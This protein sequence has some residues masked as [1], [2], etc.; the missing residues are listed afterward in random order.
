ML[1]LFADIFVLVRDSRF[2]VF[3]MCYHCWFLITFSWF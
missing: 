2:F 3:L 1:S